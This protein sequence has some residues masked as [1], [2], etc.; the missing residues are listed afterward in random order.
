LPD[1]YAIAVNAFTH[2]VPFVFIAIPFSERLTADV[3]YAF[4]NDLSFSGLNRPPGAMNG[5]FPA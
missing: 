5:R 1:L 2:H 4:K 3:P